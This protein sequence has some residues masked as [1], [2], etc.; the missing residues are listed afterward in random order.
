MNNSKAY[1]I[2]TKYLKNQ[3]LIKHCLCTRAAMIALYKNLHKDDHDLQQEEK[4]G[5]VGLLHDADYELTK[6]NENL[7][8][9]LIAKKEPQIEKD[10]LRAIASHNFE[11]T[12]VMPES[13]MDWAITCLDQLTGLI[14]A[15]T[16]VHP[17]KKLSS[18]TPEFVLKRFKE[19]SFAK[20][21]NRK[22]ILMCKEKLGINLEDFIKICLLAMQDIHASLGL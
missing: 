14:I 20:G 19:K 13:Q 5:T 21:A 15:A 11:H 8:G 3:N 1:I 22:P 12:N 2:L 9:L 7:H 16:L 10:I 17:D 6:N 4:W 18:I